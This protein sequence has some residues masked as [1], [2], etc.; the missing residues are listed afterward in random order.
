MKRFFFLA[1]IIS[2]AA[3]NDQAKKTNNTAGTTGDTSIRQLTNGSMNKGEPTVDP[4]PWKIGTAT[5]ERMKKFLNGCTSG[6]QNNSRIVD[7]NKPVYDAIQAKYPSSK[8]VEVAARYDRTD[9]FRYCALR[10]LYNHPDRCA[11]GKHKTIIYKV[12][13]DSN[14]QLTE[15]VYYDIVTLCP[16]PREC[17][18]TDSTKNQ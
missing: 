15:D 2:I 6:C 5:A 18:E 17:S 8:I 13:Q 12:A 9:E 16:P 4:T 11:V 7:Y 1:L 3:C 14:N 10:K